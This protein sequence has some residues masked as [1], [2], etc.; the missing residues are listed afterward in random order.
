MKSITENIWSWNV[1]YKT[2][3]FSGSIRFWKNF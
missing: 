3:F 2:L 1:K